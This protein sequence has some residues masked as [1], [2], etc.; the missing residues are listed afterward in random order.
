MS[1]YKRIPYGATKNMTDEEFRQ[2][3][4][5]IQ[6]RW[7]HKHPEYVK[8]ENL[9]WYKKYRE[10]KPYKCICKRCGQE[11]DAPRPYYKVCGKCPTKTSIMK[12]EIQMRKDNKKMIVEQAVAMYK[13]GL[14]TQTQVAEF[15]GT[16][17]RQISNWVKEDRKRLTKEKK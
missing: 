4:R 15:F 16:Y 9:Y 5:D 10:E 6:K 12:K 17:Q 7:R 13:T 11:F 1:G 2:Y 14:Y 8:K 3:K